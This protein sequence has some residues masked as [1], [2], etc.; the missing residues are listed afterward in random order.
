MIPSV[1]PYSTSILPYHLK[2]K[3][4]VNYLAVLIG[5]LDILPWGMPPEVHP[6]VPLKCL[7]Q[8]KTKQMVCLA[9]YVEDNPGVVERATTN[10]LTLARNAVVQPGSMKMMCSF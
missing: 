2:V 6:L 9:V 4:I 7:D 5:K 3:G 8:V 1:N 10:G